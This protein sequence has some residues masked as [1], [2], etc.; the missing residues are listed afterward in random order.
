VFAALQ[1]P[2]DQWRAVRELKSLQ[3]CLGEFQDTE[4]QRAELAAFAGQMMAEQ[5]APAATL[6]AMG[7]VAG[8]L[9]RRQRRARAEFGGLFREFAR[10]AG[11]ARIRALTRQAAT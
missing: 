4:V 11:Q 6:L 2:D 1:A 5:S 3:D 10:P 7:E 8:G 9:A